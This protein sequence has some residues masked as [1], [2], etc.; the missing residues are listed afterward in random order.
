[1]R[2]EIPEVVLMARVNNDEYEA[3]LRLEERA[4]GLLMGTM[5]KAEIK[6]ILVALEAIRANAKE[7]CTCPPCGI[8]GDWI[9]M[10]C[11]QPV[12]HV[13]RGPNGEARHLDAKCPEHGSKP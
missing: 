10:E 4:H 9:G 12:A 3:L 5:G 13:H 11:P 1:M 6:A 7:A 8:S 2:R